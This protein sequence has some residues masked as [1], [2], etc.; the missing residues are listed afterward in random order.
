M[1][2]S[3]LRVLITCPGKAAGKPRCRACVGVLKAVKLKYPVHANEIDVR[4]KKDGGIIDG[5]CITLMGAREPGIITGPA[6]EV[7]TW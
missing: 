1:I 5:T 4:A 6:E 7:G 3:E 2:P